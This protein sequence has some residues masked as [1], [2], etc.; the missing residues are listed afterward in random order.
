MKTIKS[1]R[2]WCAL[3]GTSLMVSTVEKNKQFLSKHYD[4]CTISRSTTAFYDVQGAAGH[5]VRNTHKATHFWN[6]RYIY[7]L[8]FSL[9]FF[10]KRYSSLFRKNR[11][12][13]FLWLRYT[14]VLYWVSFIR[15]CLIKGNN[16]ILP[17]VSDVNWKVGV[18]VQHQSTND[19]T[20]FKS[21]T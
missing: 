16:A 19:G 14:N 3:G 12:S 6:C 7:I 10:L 20:K 5:Q 11:L 21:Y 17:G 13:K 1:I 15:F 4:E 2:Q 9:R 18:A 8:L